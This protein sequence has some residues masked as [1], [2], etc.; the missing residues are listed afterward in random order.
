MELQK[1]KKGKANLIKAGVILGLMVLMSAPWVIW[2]LQAK[3]DLALVIVDKTVP[4]PNYREH[5]SLVWALNHL[6]V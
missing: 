2:Q 5:S 4:M 3:R 1:E 6:K